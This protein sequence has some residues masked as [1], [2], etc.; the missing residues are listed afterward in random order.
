MY[1]RE[2]M[3]EAYDF[4]IVFGARKFCAKVRSQCRVLCILHGMLRMLYVLNMPTSIHLKVLQP[5]THNESYIVSIEIDGKTS[6]PSLRRIPSS[7]VL[8]QVRGAHVYDAPCV[9][10]CL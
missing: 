1:S 4:V 6:I 2:C 3:C 8:M 5:N 10:L 9:V 7:V